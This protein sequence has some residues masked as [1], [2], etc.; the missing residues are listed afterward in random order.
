VKFAANLVSGAP[1]ARRIVSREEC[2]RQLA[3]AG[4]TSAAAMNRARSRRAGGRDG[5]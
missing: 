2:R 3:A 1:A 4:G 5:R